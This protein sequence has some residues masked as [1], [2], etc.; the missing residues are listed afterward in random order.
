ML[1]IISIGNSLLYFAFKKIDLLDLFKILVIVFVLKS[2]GY[3]ISNLLA[4]I[5][6]GIVTFKIHYEYYNKNL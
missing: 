3:K 2:K 4:L 6:E 1:S 5:R